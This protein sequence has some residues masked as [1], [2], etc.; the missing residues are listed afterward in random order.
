VTCWPRRRPAPARRRRSAS[1]SS[2]ALPRRDSGAPARAARSRSSS[3]PRASWR[4]RS[5]KRYTGTAA[6][7]A[8][9]SSRSM[10]ASPSGSSCAGCGAARRGG[11]DARPRRRSPHPRQPAAGL[12]RDGD[13]RRGGRDARHGVRGGPGRDPRRDPGHPPDGAL[14]GDDLPTIARVAARHL[15][16]PVRVSVRPERTAPEETARVRQVAYVIRGPTSSPPW[17]ESWTSRTRRRRLSSVEPAARW[18]TSPRP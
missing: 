8:R 6:T 15:H 7:S 13:P 9:A 2:S 5:P 1:P 16:E 17:A 4:C 10:A 3:C 12:G 18:T 14:L 11:G